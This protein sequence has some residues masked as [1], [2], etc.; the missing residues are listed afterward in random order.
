MGSIAKQKSVDFEPLDEGT[1]LAI[2]NA[3]VDVGLQQTP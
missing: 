2:C 3:V 1:H